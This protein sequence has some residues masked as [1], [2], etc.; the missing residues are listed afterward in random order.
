MG[1]ES[2]PMVGCILGHTTNRNVHL[3]DATLIQAA[4]RPAAASN[5]SS[6]LPNCPMAI[7]R[8]FDS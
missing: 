5:A 6:R 7:N 2:L 1:G 3:G 8:P 4:E